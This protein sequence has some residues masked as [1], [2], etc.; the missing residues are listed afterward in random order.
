LPCREDFHDARAERLPEPRELS[1]AEIDRTIRDH[2]HAAA[3]AITAGVE[4]VELVVVA[5]A[6]HLS[7]VQIS[8]LAQ[9]PSARSGRRSSWLR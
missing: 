8:S 2:R 3:M 6:E 7:V 4:G 1:G 9:G 5:A